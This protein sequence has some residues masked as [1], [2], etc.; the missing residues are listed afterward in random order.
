MGIRIRTVA[1]WLK[2][3][4]LGAVLEATMSSDPALRVRR[5]ATEHELMA[6]ARI[7]TVD[8]LIREI[9]S[10]DR[11]PSS[12]G[13]IG[14]IALAGAL[15]PSMRTQCRDLG[16]DELLVKPVSPRHV[17]ERVHALLRKSARAIPAP[18]HRSGPLRL[19]HPDGWAAANVVPLFA[20]GENRPL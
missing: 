3:A 2:N 12:V 10:F 1:I 4:A 17:H 5:F 19:D 16:I 7:A 14:T 20:L 6:Y 18:D 8:V 9:S 13:Q 15:E 11:E